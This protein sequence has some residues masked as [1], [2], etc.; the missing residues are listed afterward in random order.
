MRCA[1]CNQAIL[2]SPQLLLAPLSDLLRLLSLF[3]AVMG[4]IV[5]LNTN[6]NNLTLRSGIELC[7]DQV[8]Y[9]A[10]VQ[11]QADMIVSL[12]LTVPICTAFEWLS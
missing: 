8:V 1:Q 11:V 6:S 7:Q 2:E 10:A 12:V 9:S 5:A 3:V 4:T